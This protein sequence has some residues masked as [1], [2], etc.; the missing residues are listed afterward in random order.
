M[1]NQY[2]VDVI[3][4]KYADFN[5]RARRSEYWYF[6][7][8]NFLISMAVGLVAGLI[9]FDWLSY[10]Y[11]IALLV[12]GVAIG[13]RRLHD[14]GKSGWWLLISFVPLIGA[15]WLII[16]MVKEGNNGSNAYGPDPKA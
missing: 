11:S 3:R 8:F 16:L 1:F 2:F 7:L 14:I 6:V 12:P 15:I 9:G 4:N 10:I 13:V 5:G